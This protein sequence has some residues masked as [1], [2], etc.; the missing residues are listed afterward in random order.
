M[1]I[2]KALL[3]VLGG[4]LLLGALAAQAQTFNKR[5]KITFSQPV[6]V[7]GKVLTA[8]TYTFTI[9]DSFANRNIVQIW[10]ADKTQLITTILAIPNYRLEPTEKTVIEFRERPAGR[11]QAVKAWFYPG[12]S[13]GIEF[14]YPKEEAVQ[15]A[16]AEQE[17]VPATTAQPTPSTMATVPLVAVTPEGEEE[18]LAQ[19]FPAQPQQK[20]EQKAAPPVTVAKKLPQTASSLPLIALFGASFLGAGFAV[21]RFATKAL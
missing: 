4:V 9:L 16:Q 21:R 11:A 20:A 10:N 2:S 12:H 1:K 15:L 6:A 13:Y 5:T 19:A 18:A 3:M 14:V 8:G 7:P 17:P